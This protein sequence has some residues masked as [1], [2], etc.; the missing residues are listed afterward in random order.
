MMS[1]NVI[2]D[3]SDLNP[4]AAVFVP[5]SNLSPVNSSIELSSEDEDIPQQHW[6]ANDSAFIIAD[7]AQR[8]AA[9]AALGLA[10]F[11]MYLD[12]ED[13]LRDQLYSAPQ[14]PKGDTRSRARRG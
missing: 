5:R 9:S 14:Q 11:G 8:F 4:N 7:H 10:G 6:L 13:S 1:F 3:A 12:S 2:T